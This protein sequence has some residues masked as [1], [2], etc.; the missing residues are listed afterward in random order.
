M[1]THTN[2]ALAVTANNTGQYGTTMKAITA[3]ANF[4]DV[5]GVVNITA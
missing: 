2:T 3:K 4:D 1:K 5:G